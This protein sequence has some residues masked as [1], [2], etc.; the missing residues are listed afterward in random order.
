LGPRDGI[1][2][3]NDD[4]RLCRRL[5]AAGA[6]ILYVPTAVVIHEL[7]R[8]RVTRRYVA[9]REYFRGRSGWLVDRERHARMRLAGLG[10]MGAELRREY[11]NWRSLGVRVSTAYRIAGDFAYLAGYAG[12]AMHCLLSGRRIAPDEVE[13]KALPDPVVR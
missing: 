3:L 2:L 13:A 12:E 9:R 10:A 4:V 7:P 5:F 1:H 11:E 6:V 8:S